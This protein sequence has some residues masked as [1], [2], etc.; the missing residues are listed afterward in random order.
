M[1]RRES[2]E[3]KGERKEG[4]VSADEEGE[5]SKVESVT[6][7]GQDAKPEIMKVTPVVVGHIE[8]KRSE[9]KQGEVSQKSLN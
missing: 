6:L 8:K 4:G 5:P 7:V 1:K 9:M 2:S 3:P